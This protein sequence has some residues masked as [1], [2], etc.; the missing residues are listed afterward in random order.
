MT[1]IQIFITLLAIQQAF[2]NYEFEPKFPRDIV[3][4]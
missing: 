4:R 2:G 3:P 1:N